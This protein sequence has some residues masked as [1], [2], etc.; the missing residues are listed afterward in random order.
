MFFGDKPAWVL[1]EAQGG[2]YGFDFSFDICEVCIG[3]NLVNKEC[4]PVP[5]NT[6]IH[7]LEGIDFSRE[8]WQVRC[9]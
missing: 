1:C 8:H 9:I 4:G 6:G 7:G 2:V 5:I 3:G